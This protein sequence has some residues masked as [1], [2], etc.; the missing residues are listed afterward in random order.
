MSNFASSSKVT[1]DDPPFLQSTWSLDTIDEPKPA[2]IAKRSLKNLGF[3]PPYV[4]DDIAYL[5]F[6]S[7]PFYQAYVYRG[8]NINRQYYTAV[9]ESV[10]GHDRPVTYTFDVEEACDTQHHHLKY[11]DSSFGLERGF[12]PASQSL[13]DEV[14]EEVH[15]AARYYRWKEQPPTLPGWQSITFVDLGIVP[16]FSDSLFH[17][18]HISPWFF[19][20]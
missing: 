15:D 8:S 19:P 20:N 3:H 4:K 10:E 6:G 1:L 11:Q 7:S 9:F 16:L 13:F 2:L 14:K 18:Y 12:V 17:I 5:Q